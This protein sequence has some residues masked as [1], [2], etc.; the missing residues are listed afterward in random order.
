M[1]HL[2]SWLLG[3]PPIEFALGERTGNGRSRCPVCAAVHAGYRVDERGALIEH[4]GR[5]F[6]CRWEVAIR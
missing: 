1:D 4:A 5:R 2:F 6:P 3:P